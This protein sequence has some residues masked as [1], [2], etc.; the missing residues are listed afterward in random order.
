MQNPRKFKLLNLKRKRARSYQ[1][2]IFQSVSAEVLRIGR[3][4]IVLLLLL[5]NLGQ[6][7]ERFERV[8]VVGRDREDDAKMVPH[9]LVFLMRKKQ[10]KVIAKY[11]RAH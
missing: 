8:G 7:P 1:D 6:V 9:K 4:P 11:L 5:L 3:G 10:I 2:V